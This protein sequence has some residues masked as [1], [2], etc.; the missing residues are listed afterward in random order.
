VKVSA[1]EHRA[2]VVGRLSP[3]ASKLYQQQLLGEATFLA[4]RIDEA[5]GPE[6]QEVLPGA[7]HLVAADC[8]PRRDRAAVGSRSGGPSLGSLSAMSALAR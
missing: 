2:Y 6:A 3:Q 8:R 4:P 7:W 1:N 5:V